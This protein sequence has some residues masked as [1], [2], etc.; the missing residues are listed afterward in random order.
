MYLLQKSPPR[1]IHITIKDM[2]GWN[3]DDWIDS[4]ACNDKEISHLLWQVIN[5]S[6]NGNYT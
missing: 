4:I 3:V 1:I 5:D 6:L 2:D